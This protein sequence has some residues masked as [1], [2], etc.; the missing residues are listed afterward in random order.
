MNIFFLS[1]KTSRC[2][3]WHC[4]KHVVKMILETA[5]LLYTAHWSLG[6]PDFSSAPM[7][8]DGELGYRSIRNPG[9]PSAVWTRASLVHYIWLANLG[10]ALC[11]EYRHR[12]GDRRHAC[13]E[14]LFWLYA[15]P[16]AELE[17]CGWTQPPQAMP[18]TYRRTDSVPAYRAYYR[19]A[20]A[21]MLTYTGRTRPHWL[22]RPVKIVPAAPHRVEHASS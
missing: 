10:L 17:D 4:D 1:K 18:E 8:G 21:R 19:E 22:S 20:K 11:E 2:A 3:R 5:Q 16:P 9:H 14:H 12:F 7:R 15:H 6:E 13:E